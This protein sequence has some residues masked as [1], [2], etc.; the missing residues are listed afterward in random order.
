MYSVLIV[1]DEDVIREGLKQV[2]DWGSLGFAVKA[3]ASNGEQALH[4]LETRHFD[5]ILADVRMPKMSGIQ[6]AEVVQRRYPE[7]RV[8]ILSGYDNFKFAQQAIQY[9]VYHYLLKP[10]QEE[11]ISQVFHRLKEELDQGRERR[12]S[13]QDTEQ[14][15]LYHEAEEVLQ[16]ERDP[17]HSA[18]LLRWLA[19]FSDTSAAI[20]HLWASP[21]PSLLKEMWESG[22]DLLRKVDELEL[23]LVQNI[24]SSRILMV[25]TQGHQFGGIICSDHE[26]IRTQTESLFSGIEKELEK[27][28]SC[29]L[30]GAYTIIVPSEGRLA[31]NH[32][33]A[34]EEAMQYLHRRE[35]GGLIQIESQAESN[36]E[37]ASL[38]DTQRLVQEICTLQGGGDRKLDKLLGQWKVILAASHSLTVKDLVRWSEGLTSRLQKS[39]LDC[40]IEV[41]SR[42]RRFDKIL[43]LLSPML[44]LH[45]FFE[46]LHLLLADILKRLAER[47]AE[48]YSKNVR[49]ALQ[50]IDERFGEAVGLEEIA[51]QLSL[52]SAYLSRLFKRETGSKFSEY[53]Q[54]RRIEEAKRLLR[55]T[56]DKVYLVAARVGYPDQHYFSEIFKRRTG[57]TPM[58]YRRLAPDENRIN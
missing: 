44:T 10:C 20:L 55:D 35:P 6:L 47:H 53:L 24:D 12:A 25:H 7:K 15:L 27:R 38:P 3:T 54:K 4:E 34:L 33:R 26:S 18:A 13:Q 51:S 22:E 16:G 50:I 45:V 30:Y 40:D 21:K 39:L 17:E 43:V 42:I 32:Y 31:H 49:A 19:R 1:D 9:G 29:E 11:E 8:V 48:R 36:S 52:S 41:S 37:D 14:Q 46:L 57:F 58:D 56:N 28:I 2:L 23:E 5:V